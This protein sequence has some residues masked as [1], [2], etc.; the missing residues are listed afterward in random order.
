MSDNALVTKQ[1]SSV[2]I[3]AQLASTMNDQVA[4]IG[5]DLAEGGGGWIYA[6]LLQAGSPAV[7]ENKAKAGDWQL[8]SGEDAVFTPFFSGVLFD[9][10]G[11]TGKARQH[12][13]QQRK[14]WY[15]EEATELRQAFGSG[16]H[17][18]STNGLNPNPDSVE[19][20]AS[21]RM[22]DTRVTGAYIE[23]ERGYNTPDDLVRF[24]RMVEMA[25]NCAS[26]QLSK[27]L[28]PASGDKAIAPL[29]KTSYKA[30]FWVTHVHGQDDWTPQMVIVE[31]KGQ[32]ERTFYSS[33][34]NDRTFQAANNL[35]DL[36][37]Q[38]FPSSGFA[39]T[40]MLQ[41][42]E[43]SAV[44]PMIIAAAHLRNDRSQAFF[45]PYWR[46]PVGFAAGENVSAEVLETVKVQ[47]RDTVAA[48]RFL[49][50]AK[51]KHYVRYGKMV[52][53]FLLSTILAPD[54]EGSAEVLKDL[55]DEFNLYWEKTADMRP[56]GRVSF[57]TYRERQEET[58][59]GDQAF[60]APAPE[61]ATTVPQTEVPAMPQDATTGPTTAEVVQLPEDPGWEDADEDFG[62]DS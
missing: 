41:H 17:C 12:N 48:A 10:I 31:G 50:G 3:F 57:T 47:T 37:G 40:Y 29:C 13:P 52:E 39:T 4:D 9:I 59:D 55:M 58:E 15:P 25:T 36:F 46:N 44:I 38:G 30:L 8:G 5:G 23:A 43:G 42:A 28:R 21:A 51:A 19:R 34:K 53:N 62:W 33:N 26:C 7:Q 45:V 18:V 20:F 27:W 61:A 2:S 56:Q 16:P 14:M 35:T 54:I 1:D 22:V 32:G 6:N 24:E 11:A 60:Q 49:D